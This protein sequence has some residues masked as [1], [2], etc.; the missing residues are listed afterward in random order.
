MFEKENKEIFNH[1]IENFEIKEALPASPQKMGAIFVGNGCNVSI[2]ANTKNIHTIDIHTSVRDNTV[3]QAWRLSSKSNDKGIFCGFIP[4]LEPGDFYHISAHDKLNQNQRLLDPYARAITLEPELRAIVADEYFDWEGDKQL[5]IPMSETIIYEGHVKGLTKLMD[6]IPE[7]IRG[8]YAG[9]ASDKFIS[10]L[11]KLGITALE[12][13]PIQQFMSEPELIKRNQSN[14]WGYN[15]I[16]FF[17]PHAEYS[18]DKRPGAQVDEF[19]NMVKKLHQSGIEVILDVVYNH[20]AEGPDN[21]RTISFKGLDKEGY[22]HLENGKHC[23]FSGCGNTFNA[24]TDA[25]LNFIIESLEYWAKQMHVDGFRFDLA[26]C[27]ARRDKDHEVDMKGRFMK[28]LESNPVLRDLKLIFEPWDCKNNESNSYPGDSDDS[29]SRPFKCWVWNGNT[30]DTIRKY[31]KGDGDTGELASSLAGSNLKSRSINLATAHDGFTLND[32]TS[33]NDKHNYENG[34]YNHD[35]S[36]NNHSRHYG[37]EGPTDDPEVNSLRRKVART[38]LMMTILANGTPM[39][40][41]GDEILRTQNGNNNAYCQDNETTWIDWNITTDKEKFFEFTSAIID[42]RKKNGVFK[43]S[44]PFTG[45]SPSLDSIETDVAWFRDDGRQFEINDPAWH[46]KQ[47]LG[48]YLSGIALKNALGETYNDHTYLFYANGTDSDQEIIL[49]KD[50]H[51]AG[52][53]EL[54]VD[55][56]KEDSFPE[57]EIIDQETLV[58]KPLSAILLRKIASHLYR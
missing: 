27:L 55:T 16:G 54:V 31:S 41:H 33:Y 6:D 4:D 2:Y 29:D 43:R 50:K 44:S 25:G 34:E 40:S 23:D 35:G 32:C 37:V 8:T 53:H 11:K 52:V 22:Y 30:R 17:A 3:A 13:M 26:P 15:T 19:K 51:Y 28:A 38:M 56:S 57:N 45:Q 9:I 36:D 1:K 20:T 14:Y 12:L 7:E 47:L 58:V 5:N 49:P 21:G 46:R 48:M 18:S 10:H 42:I 39:I 24:S